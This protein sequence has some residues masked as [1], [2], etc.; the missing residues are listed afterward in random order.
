MA[1]S[2]LL[3]I[4]IGVDMD[5]SNNSKQTFGATDGEPAWY[6][7]RSKPKH[8]HIAAANLS[9]LQVVETFNPS[10]RSR[11]ATRRG[12]VWMTESLFPNYIFAR[13]PFEQMFDEVKYTRGVSSLVHFGTGYPEVPADVI[14]ELRRNFPA[15]ELKLS[16]EVPTA[17]DQVTITSRALFGLQGVVLRTMPAQRRVQVLLDMLG[18]TSAVELNLNSVV[19]ERQPLPSQLLS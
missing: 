9:K 4:V 1:Y 11:K 14:E 15:N 8:E 7:V 19:V 17:G 13:F 3:R 16:S 18:Q 5:K 10:L 2:N 6:C 12:P